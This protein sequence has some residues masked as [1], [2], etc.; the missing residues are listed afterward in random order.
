VERC[1][2]DLRE[3][4]APGITIRVSD[5]IVPFRETIIVPPRADTRNELIGAD[6]TTVNAASHYL[7]DGLVVGADGVARVTTQ[8]SRRWTLQVRAQPLPE[9][10]THILQANECVLRSLHQEVAARRDAIERRRRL[11]SGTRSDYDLQQAWGNETIG[12]TP[13]EVRVEVNGIVEG[14]A[15]DPV[16]AAAADRIARQ[17]H[18]DL[19]LAFAVAG[20][21]WA[22]TVERIWAFGPRHVGANMLVHHIPDLPV[23]GFFSAFESAEVTESG[24]GTGIVQQE[25]AGTT[26]TEEEF[27]LSSTSISAAVVR[28]LRRSIS[29]VEVGF[30]VMTQAGPLCEEPMQGVCFHLEAI[31]IADP[32]VNSGTIDPG[33]PGSVIGASREACRQAFLAQPAR[34]VAAMYACDLVVSSAS[35]GRVYDVLGRR[36]GRVLSEE[37]KEGSDSFLIHA[38]LPVSQSF[39]F[40]G[41]LRSRTS[42]LAV[43]QLV[44]SHWE[45]IAEDPFWVPAT[46]TELEHYG[47]QGDA[48]NAARRLMDAVR[49]RKG[50]RV[51]EKL[52][53]FAYKQR[54]LA[55]KK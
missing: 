41:E 15:D 13:V 37:M 35:L 22:G 45:T 38:V 14:E 7:L 49:R 1:L 27:P 44:F 25:M 20:P 55:K 24:Y 19:V 16:A 5:P 6:N 8:P 30:Q 29:S 31:D 17:L 48:P 9:A 26:S 18:A 3:S 53:E 33:F 39:G 40:A 47:D 10:V 2:T 42:G 23:H 4:F 43:P 52:V 36:G 11:R 50:L 12:T 54:T 21:E 34:L 28:E 51:E 32:D 46:E